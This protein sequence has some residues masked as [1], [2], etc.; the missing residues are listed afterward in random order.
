MV[1][2]LFPLRAYKLSMFGCAYGDFRTPRR[3]VVND[4]I[5][6]QILEEHNVF[7]NFTQNCVIFN[8][9]SFELGETIAEWSKTLCYFIFCSLYDLSKLDIH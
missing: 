4:L 2:T 7:R 1:L 5:L 8:G 9:L 3:F 6:C